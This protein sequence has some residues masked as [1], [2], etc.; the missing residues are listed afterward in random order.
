MRIIGGTLKGRRLRPP[1][2]NWPV[3]PTTDLA[4]EALFNILT[5]Y[6]DFEE[7]KVL[8]LFGGMGGHS[9]EFVSRGCPDVTYVERLGP[10]VAFVQQTAEAWGVSDRMRIVR[11]D[12]FRYVPGCRETFDYVFADPPYDL[13]QLET[14]PELVFGHGLLAPGGWFVLEHNTN[15]SFRYH[16]RFAEERRYGKTLFS[17]FKQGQE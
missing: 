9:F 2:R 7:M 10:A 3:R 4:R 6:W 16:P 1:A 15:H 14:L 12:V 8:D 13:P 17:I 11:A 5:N